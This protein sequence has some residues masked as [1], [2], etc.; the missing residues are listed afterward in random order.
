V[1]TYREM[2]EAVFRQLG[3]PPRIVEVPLPA[4]RAAIGAARWIPG[5]GS[6]SPEMASRMGVDLC[7]D[8]A[9]AAR[10]FGFRPRPFQ[11]DDIAV[12]RA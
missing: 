10:D 11:L 9:E 4:L 1:L 12:G 3:R 5:M 7:F 6:L 8:H 2:V